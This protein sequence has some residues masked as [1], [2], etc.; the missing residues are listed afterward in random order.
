MINLMKL[1]EGKYDYG[2][3]MACI[4]QD[5]AGKILDFNYKTVHENFIYT[6]GTEYGREKHPHVTIKYGLTQSYTEEQM[7]QVLRNVIPFDI[8]VKGVGIFE[9]DRFDVVK[10]EV[11]GRELRVLNEL[12]SKLPNHD[13]HPIYTPHMTLA[14]VK[15]GHGKRFAR[16]ARG[17]S[18]IPVRTLEYSDRGVKT[19]LNL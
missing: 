16:N 7:K 2:C 8:K 15:K 6:E 19:F 12:F 5:A 1:Y 3:I 14:Y 11:D 17:V 13:S 4:D 9:N 18:R 10:L